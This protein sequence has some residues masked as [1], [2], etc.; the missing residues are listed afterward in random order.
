MA[1]RLTKY[2][3]FERIGEVKKGEVVVKVVRR[4]KA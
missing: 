4:E 2:D 3:Q 1:K